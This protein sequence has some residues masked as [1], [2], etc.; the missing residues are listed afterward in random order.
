MRR[1]NTGVWIALIVLLL[2]QAACRNA[3]PKNQA[4]SGGHLAG[5]QRPQIDHDFRDTLVPTVEWTAELEQLRDNILGAGCANPCL[6]G[7][8][9]GVTT[10]D[11]VPVILNQLQDEG[12]LNFYLN[13]H[14]IGL[15]YIFLFPAGF[16]GDIGIREE[17]NLV[18]DVSFGLSI[19]FLTLGDVIEAYGEPDLVAY[20]QGDTHEG[21]RFFYSEEQIFLWARTD[22][23]GDQ[24]VSF[25]M[26]II[27]LYYLSSGVINHPLES[28]YINWV[29]WEGYLNI[30][31]YYRKTQPEQYEPVN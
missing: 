17:T 30:Y 7:I 31:D 26:T 8:T 27:T 4:T 19:Q 16:G 28:P 25:D 10:T 18:T 24:P 9:P 20:A 21:L 3:S 14:P 29:E 6:F 11:E 23:F 12:I 5:A 1:I 2:I 13:N 15:S 22:S